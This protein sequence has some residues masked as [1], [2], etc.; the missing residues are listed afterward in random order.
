[1]IY[2]EESNYAQPG[3]KKER[4]RLGGGAALAMEMDTLTL[5]MHGFKK[6]EYPQSWLLEPDFL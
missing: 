2:K 5:F 3:S 4:G 6:A 1:M